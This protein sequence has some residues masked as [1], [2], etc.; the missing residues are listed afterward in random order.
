MVFTHW[1]GADKRESGGECG[2]EAAGEGESEGCTKLA[3]DASS[4]SEV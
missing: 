3:E 2:G 1:N 4:L